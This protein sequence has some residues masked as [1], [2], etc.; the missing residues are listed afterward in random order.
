MKECIRRNTNGKTVLLLFVLCNIIYGIMLIVTIPEV[1]LHSGGM[2]ILDM[3]P[4]GYDVH[5]VNSLFTTLGTD[6]RDLYLTHQLPL[7]LLYPALFGLSSCL[8][9]AYFLN[10]LKKLDSWLFY[11]CLLPLASGVFDYIENFGIISLLKSYP[12]ISA[13]QVRITSVFTILKSVFTSIYFIILSIT[14]LALAKNK[15]FVKKA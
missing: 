14:L 6:G 8:V 13:P 7:D 2:K 3:M 11:L 4:T 9:L 1:M 10:K 15:I 5:Y 12:Y